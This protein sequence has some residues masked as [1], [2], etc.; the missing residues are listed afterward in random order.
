MR[1]VHVEALTINDLFR[2][3]LALRLRLVL[4]LRTFGDHAL[5]TALVD[6]AGAYCGDKAIS[7]ISPCAISTLK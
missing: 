7:E 3:C 1:D 5:M 4:L 2:G 6:N